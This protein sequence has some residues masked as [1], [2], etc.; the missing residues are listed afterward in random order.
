LI[1]KDPRGM[2]TSAPE[3]TRT[4]LTS[5]VDVAPLLL[6]IAS[7]SNEWRKA[8]RYAHLAHRLDIARILSDPA[9]PGRPYVL[10]ATDEVVTEFATEPYSAYAPLHVVALRTPEAKYA[11]YSHWRYG[12]IVPLR[13][14]QERE[15]YDYASQSGRLELENSAG[16]SPL[17]GS[18]KNMY[19]RAFA[20]ELRR[21]L[22]S[23]LHVAR[24]RGFF[25]YFAV[26]TRAS[27]RAAQ[28][29]AEV[30]LRM[31][32]PEALTTRL[33]RAKRAHAPA[34]AR[35]ARSARAKRAGARAKRRAARARRFFRT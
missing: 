14:G 4:Q 31:Q 20:T 34:A 13:A 15:L 3:R 35:A 8:P 9:A 18:L 17:E 24:R 23:H 2:L 1:V 22:P 7:G 5:S 19:E 6:T 12:K 32:P 25:D 28:H 11:T 16:L 29:R 26:A 10:H 30:E 33:R 27:L 21:P